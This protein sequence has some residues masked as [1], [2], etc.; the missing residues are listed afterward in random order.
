MGT[1]SSLYKAEVGLRPTLN[2]MYGG[3]DEKLGQTIGRSTKDAKAVR[4]KFEKS[5]P[6]LK[7]LREAVSKAAERGYLIALDGRKTPVRAKHAALNTLL[8][9]AGAIVSKNW[10]LGI[11]RRYKAEGLDARISLFVHDESDAIVITKDVER[12]IQIPSES[13][14]EVEEL[15]KMNVQLGCETKT[16]K[17]WYEIH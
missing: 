6:A 13:L 16:G 7:S 5:L 10:I 14:K 8:Q 15:L 2:I 1:Y 9:G 17:T 12:A 11:D 4:A 3:G